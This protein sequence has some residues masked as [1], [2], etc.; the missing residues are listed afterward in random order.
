[1]GFKIIDEKIIDAGV[2]TADI[3]SVEVDARPI[4]TL[5]LYAK[6]TGAPTGSL[7]LQGSAN[8]VD[9]FDL[10]TATALAGSGGEKVFSLDGIPWK[11]VRVFY[12]FTSG[13]GAL[14]VWLNSK[15]Q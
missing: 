8:G 14:D 5:G 7:K 11:L 15:G 2:M 1:M 3:L 12:D 10:E 4:Y 13:T 6:W 9:W